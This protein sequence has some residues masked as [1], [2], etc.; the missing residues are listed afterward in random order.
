MQAAFWSAGAFSMGAVIPLV[1]AIVA[2]ASFLVWIV[3]IV[4]IGILGA[5]GGIAAATGG[6]SIL[7]GALRVCF[8]GTAAMGLTAVV[9]KL[10][11]IAA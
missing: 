11:G 3:P 9:G 5:L 10:F 1:T 4:A 6:A 8:W 2:P 7:R